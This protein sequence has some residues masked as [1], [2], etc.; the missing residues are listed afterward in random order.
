METK[1][2]AAPWAW[3]L[4]GDTYMLA[5]QHG[6]REII[7]GAI[8]APEWKYPVP[9]MTD[10]GLLK[11]VDNQHA[12]AKLIAAAPELLEALQH[13]AEYEERG[14]AKGEPRISEKWYNEV[15]AA[16]KKATE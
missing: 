12:N 3:Q 10:K 13:I 9:A 4:F 2:T 6:R 14:R 1:Y 7:I 8:E 15:K 11:V 16:I 5:A